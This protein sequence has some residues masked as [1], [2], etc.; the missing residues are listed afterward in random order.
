MGLTCCRTLPRA[1]LDILR[2][3]STKVKFK[4]DKL[5][6]EMG[7]R[8]KKI[9]A[10]ALLSGGLDSMLA[11]WLINSQGVEVEAITFQSYFFGPQKGVAAAKQLGIPHRVIDFSEEHLELVKNPPHGYGKAANPCIDCHR[12]MLQKA[13][14]IL[15]KEGFDF[16]VT[17][18]TLGQRPFSQNQKAL[19]IVAQE[20]GLGDRLVRPLSAQ[21]LPMTE[22][23]KRGW[24]KRE[25]LLAVRGRS[26]KTQI[27]LAKKLGLKFPQPAGGC[28]LTDP[29]FGQ[30]LKELFSSWSDCNA[31][32]IALLKLGRHYWHP[33]SDHQIK[34]VI[35]RDRAENQNLEQLAQPQD[36][37]VQP[38]NFVGPSALIR[39]KNIS[40][41]S[42]QKAQELILRHTP[43]RKKTI[44]PKNISF[45]FFGSGSEAAGVLK[46]LLNANLVPRAIIS[47]PDRPAGRGQ[48]LQPTPVSQ[49]AQEQGLLFASPNLIKPV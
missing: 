8:K 28:L 13:K 12:L 10:L 6:T 19:A 23:E 37:L 4:Y 17:G 2:S 24:I 47:Q 36:L 11:A 39:G 26:R 14:E 38:A 35:G 33:P 3:I 20:S 21:L 34:I 27:Q 32:D 7:L 15:E 44:N 42:I 9:R 18:E 45:L 43:P 48:R 49:L 5:T 1:V 22:P 25:K 46:A 41:A 31:N 40:P 30:K 16:V 29:I